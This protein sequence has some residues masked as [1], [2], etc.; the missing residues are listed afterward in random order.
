MR[1]L[2]MS[3]F[4]VLGTL[5]RYG[6]QGLVQEHS[7]AG[8]PTGTL[9][10]NLSGCFF[11]GLIGQFALNHLSFPP[12]WRIAITVGFFGAFTTFSTFSWETGHMLMDGEWWKA[13]AYVGIS[14]V[15]G[16]A[17]LLAGL[18]VADRFS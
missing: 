13:G 10:V 18:R 2:L 1:I 12:D 4:G 6:L 3:V 16:V 14:L 5:T 11:L 17:L 8:F 15:F 7:G 9:V